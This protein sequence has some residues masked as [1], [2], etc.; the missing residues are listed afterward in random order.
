MEIYIIILIN[1][2]VIEILYGIF[3][4]SC[5]I[6]DHREIKKAD[7]SVL[8]ISS[9]I[10]ARVEGMPETCDYFY[11]GIVLSILLALIPAVCRLCRLTIDNNHLDD[12]LS[13]FDLLALVSEKMS[14]SFAILIDM[15]FGE[16]S[17]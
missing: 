9:T 16:S 5:T 8:D 11:G 15:G 4:V 12:H 3:I 7:L 14:G 6:W 1:F 10:I 2:Y 13:V 17:T